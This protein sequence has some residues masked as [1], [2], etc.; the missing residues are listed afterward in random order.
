MMPCVPK[1][2]QVASGVHRGGGGV[3][4]L[5]CRVELPLLAVRPRRFLLCAHWCWQAHQT[6]HPPTLVCANRKNTTKPP[7]PALE[8]DETFYAPL[9]TSKQQALPGISRPHS[10]LKKKNTNKCAPRGMCSSSQLNI[11]AHGR[12]LSKVNTAIVQWTAGGT[13]CR[14]SCYNHRSNEKRSETHKGSGPSLGAVQGPALPA[15]L[16]TNVKQLP[17][18]PRVFNENAE[19]MRQFLLLE[20][21]FFALQSG[22]RF[23]NFRIISVWSAPISEIAGGRGAAFF[24]MMGASFQWDPLPRGWGQATG[25]L[26]GFWSIH[27]SLLVFFPMCRFT[28]WVSFSRAAQWLVMWAAS[29]KI[30]G[31][32]GLS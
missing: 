21:I 27:D 25:A 4:S 2:L 11:G 18:F 3:P 20:C 6:P 24:K 13:I 26:A 23:C 8:Q 7:S 10:P 5:V 31:V 28:T 12:T 19:E 17:C 16:H 29:L 9:N 22:G 1:P 15:F 30:L 14:S 32:T